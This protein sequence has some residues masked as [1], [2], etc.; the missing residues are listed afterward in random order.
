MNDLN[1]TYGLDDKPVDDTANDADPMEV[2]PGDQLAGI[3]QNIMMLM[4]G[5]EADKQA[6]KALLDHIEAH[7][8]EAVPEAEHPERFLH[9]SAHDLTLQ[10]DPETGLFTYD[11]YKAMAAAATSGHGSSGGGHLGAGLYTTESLRRAMF[12]YNEVAR[13]AAQRADSDPVFLNIVNN[14]LQPGQRML[15]LNTPLAAVAETN[16]EAFRKWMVTFGKDAGPYEKRLQYLANM[17][18]ADRT[19]FQNGDILRSIEGSMRADLPMQQSSVWKPGGSLWGG[20]LRTPQSYVYP[21]T[22]ATFKDFLHHPEHL[23]PLSKVSNR[24][25]I[26]KKMVDQGF[27]IGRNV[28]EGDLPY[29]GSPHEY[30]HWDPEAGLVHKSIPMYPYEEVPGRQMEGFPDRLPNTNLL[31]KYLPKELR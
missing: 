27:A 7:G 1:D 23:D 20:N 6:A 19:T 24:L 5:S 13:Q 31:D 29:F 28:Q 17:D 15:D 26:P 8:I 10:A 3:Y 21:G 2:H 18:P 9:T 30:V 4:G 16:P 11:P 22:P 14:R 25:S 12:R